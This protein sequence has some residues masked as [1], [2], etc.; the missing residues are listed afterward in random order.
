MKALLT[1]ICLFI[2]LSCFAQTALSI[3]ASRIF[4][5]AGGSKEEIFIIK[6][7][8]KQDTL[9][10]EL[11]FQDWDYDSI[12]NNRIYPAGELAISLA[13]Y[14]SIRSGN[15]ITLAPGATDTIRLAVQ[16]IPTDSI[17]VRTAMLYL[18]QINKVNTNIASSAIK[19]FV[20]MGIKIYYKN[21]GY[22]MPE[23]QLSNFSLVG[24]NQENKSLKLSFHNK[25][26]IWLD[27]NIQYE[28]LNLDTREMIKLGKT[29]FF[30][31]PADKQQVKIDL[32]MN[33]K[34]G[35]Y[36]A[37]AFVEPLTNNGINN[38]ELIFTN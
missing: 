10:I 3:S 38:L 21:S 29:E 25:G 8:N 9:E 34:P 31:L 7:P 13:N 17:P 12:G 37:Y 4:F 22:P 1:G 5:A 33:L 19:M 32:P 36:K 20:Q 28:L 24:R 15:Y 14:L 23:I 2:Q 30:S 26:N 6:N 27:G 18:A 11:S 16:T 35:N